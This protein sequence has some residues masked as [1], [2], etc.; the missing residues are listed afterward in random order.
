MLGEVAL[1]LEAPDCGARQAGPLAN[2]WKAQQSNRE[3]S[4]VALRRLT[5][6]L[7]RFGGAVVLDENRAKACCAELA[8]IVESVPE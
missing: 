6:V 2:G 8:W 3:Y 4:L 7:A 5:P 1:A